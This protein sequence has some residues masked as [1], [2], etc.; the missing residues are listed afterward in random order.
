MKDRNLNETMESFREELVRQERSPATREKYLREAERFLC[1]ADEREVSKELIVAYKQRLFDRGYSTSTVNSTIAALNSLLRFLGQEECRVRGVRRQRNLYCVPDRELNIMEYRRLVR[2]AYKIGERRLA[3]VMETLCSAG[4]RV[5][6]LYCITVEAAKMGVAEVMMKGKTRKIFLVPEMQ[7]KLLDYAE[8]EG[9]RS[10]PIFVTRTGRPLDRSNIW[11]EMKALCAIAHVKKDKVF[12]HN[13]RHLFAREFYE[14]EKDVVKLADLLGH[15]SIDTTRIYVM[16]S[17]Q[18]H[19]RSL[20][21][22]H[23]C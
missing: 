17:G 9:I 11:R 19:R 4:M 22:M 7:Y 20:S 15:S 18:E 21:K 12:P 5:S 6:E 2:T 10:G 3:V 14:M 23:L 13:L 1:W 16:T 8:Q